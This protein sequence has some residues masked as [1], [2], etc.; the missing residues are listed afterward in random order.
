VADIFLLSLI[1]SIAFRAPF[2]RLLLMILEL[3]I[4]VNLALMHVHIPANALFGLVV[5]KPLSEF[6]FQRDLKHRYEGYTELRY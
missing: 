2:D 4:M 3:Q 6:R 1:I 5:Y